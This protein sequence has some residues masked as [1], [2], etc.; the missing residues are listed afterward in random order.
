MWHVTARSGAVRCAHWS[1]RRARTAGIEPNG[2]RVPWIK[3]GGQ[4]TDAAAA[5]VNYNGG[6]V[7][8]KEEEAAAAAVASTSAV[9]YGSMRTR[10]CDTAAAPL[11]TYVPVTNV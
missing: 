7:S 11:H 3:L 2:T 9:E 6:A 8:A 1:H 4:T 5:A 10:R